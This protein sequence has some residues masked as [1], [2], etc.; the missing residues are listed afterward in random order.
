MQRL[1]PLALILL[2]LA[3]SVS[4]GI[5]RGQVQADGAVVLCSGTT[6][7]LQP[8]GGDGEPGPRALVCPDMAPGLMVAIAL[9]T[10]SL[11]ERIAQAGLTAHDANAL[12]VAGQGQRPRQGRGPPVG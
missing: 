9:P 1:A 11:P 2:M 7:S 5:A 8:V 10:V 3:T 6:I 12:T 4:L